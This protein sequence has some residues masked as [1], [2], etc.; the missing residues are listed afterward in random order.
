[1]NI[2]SFKTYLVGAKERLRPDPVRDWLVLVGLSVI[3]LAGII[4]W[5]INAFDTVAMG[6]IIGGQT[7]SPPPLVNQETIDSIRSIFDIRSAEE[8]KYQTGTYDF[9]DPSR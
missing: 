2:N 3:A 7:A 8:A 6:G 4:V 1:M 9:I 5:N